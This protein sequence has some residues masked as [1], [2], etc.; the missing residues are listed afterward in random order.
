MSLWTPDG[1]HSVPREQ[2]SPAPA[3][4]PPAGA[5][6]PPASAAGADAA[7]D[8]PGGGMSDA[9]MAEMLGLPN[10]DELS[11]EQRAQAEAMVAEMA[12]TQRQIASA[13]AEVVVANHLMG[14]YELAAIHLSQEPPNLPDAK[15]AIDA[16]TGTMEAT[17][18][19]LGEA[20]ATL[21]QALAQIQV[22]FVDR[23]GAGAE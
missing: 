2:P 13:P 20:E 3:A 5:A 15:L 12:E 8:G 19:R 4:T 18:G 11:P 14:F 17:K 22:A 10:L 9:A 23:S 21:S 6:A 1:E 16:M 7:A